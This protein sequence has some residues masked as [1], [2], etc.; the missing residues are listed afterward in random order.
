MACLNHTKGSLV[1]LKPYKTNVNGMDT[2][3]MLTDDDAKTR[4]LSASD[5]VK[6]DQADTEQSDRKQAARP[7]NKAASPSSDKA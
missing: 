2:V 7:A 4:G 3:L 6:T 1:E 5:I